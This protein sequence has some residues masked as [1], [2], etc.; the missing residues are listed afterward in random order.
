MY[1]QPSGSVA[2]NA[3]ATGDL[4]SIPGSGRSPGVG[5]GYPFQCSYLENPMDTGAWRVMVPRVAK[6]RTRLKQISTHTHTF[7]KIEPPAYE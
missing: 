4:G 6:S 2:C 3:G 1:I 7:M 5:N